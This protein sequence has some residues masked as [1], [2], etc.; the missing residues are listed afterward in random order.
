MP[1]SQS[2]TEWLR[3]LKAG[4]GDAAQLLWERYFSQL[5]RVS[6]QRLPACQRRV[7]DEEDVALSVLD[8]FCRGAA[9][10]RFPR[11]GDRHGL[12]PLLVTI[13]MRKVGK[14]ARRAHRLKHGAGAV[15]GES[16]LVRQGERDAAAAW[17]EILGNEPNPAF[18]CEMNDECAR[19][20]DLLDDPRLREIA[21][22]KM[23]GHTNAE[24]AS[25]LGCVETTVERKLKIIRGVW[26]EEVRR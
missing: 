25:K 21:V 16:A 11:L 15:R 5:V 1:S 6:R 7:A 24:I 23:E 20:L 9:R 12:W 19:L 26:A 10:G 22:W 3:R 13:T 18:A 8:S 4:D 2:V 14:L 17:D